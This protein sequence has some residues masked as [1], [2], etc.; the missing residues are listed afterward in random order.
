MTVGGQDALRPCVLPF[1]YR[2]VKYDACALDDA[3]DGKAW[4]PTSV[5]LDERGLGHYHSYAS[6]GVC[7]PG[8]DRE[9]GRSCRTMVVRNSQR[10]RSM[11]N[12]TCLDRRD[13]W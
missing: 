12:L 11:H 4:C 3:V 7:G 9:P 1:V 6:W 5:V 2:G 10:S 8:C 13:A